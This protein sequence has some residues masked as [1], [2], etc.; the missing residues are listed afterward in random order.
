MDGKNQLQRQQK[1]KLRRSRENHR[2]RAGHQQHTT[3]RVL[4]EIPA[5]TIFHSFSVY[6]GKKLLNEAASRVRESV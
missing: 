2:R 1:Q 5:A 4:S 3:L 6:F